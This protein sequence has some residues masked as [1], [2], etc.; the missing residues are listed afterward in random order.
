MSASNQVSGR[1]TDA[2]DYHRKPYLAGVNRAFFRNVLTLC[3]ETPSDREK[4]SGLLSTIRE[5]FAQSTDQG[6][7]EISFSRTEYDAAAKR[8]V[9]RLCEDQTTA[10]GVNQRISGIVNSAVFK[11]V[12]NSVQST[13]FREVHRGVELPY[14]LQSMKKD[15]QADINLSLDPTLEDWL[16]TAWCSF[17]P[18]GREKIGSDGL[19]IKFQHLVAELSVSNSVHFDSKD[20]FIDESLNL[21]DDRTVARRNHVESRLNVYLD[22]SDLGYEVNFGKESYSFLQV[23]KALLSQDP[24]ALKKAA[25]GLQGLVDSFDEGDRANVRLLL[26]QCLQDRKDNVGRR[27]ANCTIL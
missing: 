9:D 2:F 23:K 24:G 5:T 13:A 25:P 21:G 26:L 4:I 12:A 7:N 19:N 8:L 15:A 3:Y 14:F 16:A 1:P 17:H 10:C 22:E 18:F 6:G 11:L 27:M 20:V